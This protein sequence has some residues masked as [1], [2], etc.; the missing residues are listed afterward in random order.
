M[1]GLQQSYLLL[2]I[3]VLTNTNTNTNKYVIILNGLNDHLVS[4]IG[5][6]LYTVTTVV[7]ASIPQPSL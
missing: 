5:I 3:K 4:V 6:F 1:V 7:Y 2:P